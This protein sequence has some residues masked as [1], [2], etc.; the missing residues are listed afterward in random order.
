MIKTLI[1]LVYA[2]YSFAFSVDSSYN[3]AHQKAIKENK[4]LLVFLS[5]KECPHCN[6]ELYKILNNE[7]LKAALSKRAVFVVVFKNQNESYP[8]EMLYTLEYPTLF[9]LDKYELFSCSAMR[10]EIEIKGLLECIESK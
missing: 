2:S 7:P 6:K 5:K 10:S 9:F 3:R 8:V 1:V 4:M